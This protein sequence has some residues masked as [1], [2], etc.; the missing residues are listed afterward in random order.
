MFDARDGA[1]NP[2]GRPREFD[3]ETALKGAMDIFWR[4]G[5]VATN[6]P[7][8]LDAMGLTRGS[9]YK[10]FKDKESVYLT[11][12]D[13]YDREVVSRTVQALQ[14]C[15]AETASE[16]LSLIFAAPADPGRGCFICNAMVELGPVQ[17]EVK[18]R[19]SRM[20]DRLR[21]AIKGVLIRYGTQD[22]AEETA[23]VILHLYFGHQA[24]GKAAAGRADWPQRL[25][26]VLAERSL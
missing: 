24:L 2:M 10:A 8:L 16:C 5:Y 21:D 6:L 3:T 17:P 22:G 23:D 18:A 25:A 20:A 7:D 26:H 11:T 19:T 15:E 12:L 13:H 4:Q 1:L 14:T 9:F